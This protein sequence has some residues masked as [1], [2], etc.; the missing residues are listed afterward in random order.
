MV[1]KKKAEKDAGA[2][3]AQPESGP[4]EAPVE[5]EAAVNGEEAPAAAA[6]ETVVEAPVEEDPLLKLQ[7]EVDELKDRLIRAV[8]ETENVRRRADKERQDAAK[9]AAS[10][11]AKDLLDTIDNLGRAL[12]AV[13]EDAAEKD[14][15]TKNLLV[16]VRM[17]QDGILQALERQG[18]KRIDPKGEKFSYD[19]HQAMQEVTNSG[20]PAGTV[21][22]VLAAG[23]VMH[24]RLLRP[25]MVIVAKGD[26]NQ[27]PDDVE[28]VDTTA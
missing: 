25:A 5:A 10:G 11:L 1:D 23:Y 20:Q 27:P 24:D 12:A 3:E 9:Y 17:I 28:H 8:A 13:P 16:G 26:P 21:V 18:I 22:E 7:A 4:E 6:E 2:R 14:E 15:V 19:L